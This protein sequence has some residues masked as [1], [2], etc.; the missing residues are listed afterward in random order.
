MPEFF[1]NNLVQV[2]S[3]EFCKICKNTFF[4]EQNYTHKIF[5]IILTALCLFLVHI[6]WLS[7][8]EEDCNRNHERKSKNLSINE[9]VTHFPSPL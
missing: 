2:F 9:I 3:G 7:Q 6:P 4:I 8:L 5:N 1:F